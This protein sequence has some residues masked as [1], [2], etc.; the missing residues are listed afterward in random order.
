[1][2]DPVTGKIWVAVEEL[3]P[4]GHSTQDVQFGLQGGDVATSAP[5]LLQQRPELSQQL[6]LRTC[7]TILQTKEIEMD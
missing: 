4:E 6:T 1:M 2:V 7:S 5:H 3:T